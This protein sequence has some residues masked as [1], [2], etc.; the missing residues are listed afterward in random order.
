MHL[1]LKKLQKF[2]EDFGACL[3]KNWKKNR[4]FF[5]KF[6]LS[7]YCFLFHVRITGFYFINFLLSVYWYILLAKYG[8]QEVFEKRILFYKLPVIRIL[9]C[10]YSKVRLTGSF[11][12]KS[13][14][15]YLVVFSK[16]TEYGLQEFY[17]KKSC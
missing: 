5:F 7:V 2:S 6:L 9:I 13:C 4:I 11:W 1:L 17:F 8:Q 12:K 15:P 14:Y 16:L 3:K 10:W